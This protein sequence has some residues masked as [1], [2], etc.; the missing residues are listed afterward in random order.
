MKFLIF[1]LFFVAVFGYDK[2]VECDLYNQRYPNLTLTKVYSEN[3]T[4]TCEDICIEYLCPVKFFDKHNN[5]KVYVMGSGCREDVIKNCEFYI[6]FGIN[7]HI[8]KNHYIY[9]C[10]SV[11]KNGKH[12]RYFPLG[13]SLSFSK[14]T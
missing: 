10:I 3:T 6:D 13:K 4:K 14:L 8:Y 1:P 7:H 5:E 11:S 12:K 2:Y 9:A